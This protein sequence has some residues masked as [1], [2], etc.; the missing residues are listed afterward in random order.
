MVDE[1][2][3]R[4]REVLVSALDT[5][6][7]LGY[8]GTSMEEVAR[9]ARISR[10]GLYLYFASKPELLRAAVEHALDRDAV[11][12]EAVLADRAAPLRDRLRDAL[13]VWSGQYV[14][15]LAADLDGLIER[16]G[17]LLGDLPQRYSTRFR[18][19]LAEAVLAAAAA[20]P[21]AGGASVESLLDVL[22]TISVGLKHRARD[23][24][25]F[26]ERLDAALG[27]VLR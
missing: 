15:P 14:G 4:R 12:C 10:P 13:E 20:G 26:A 24:Q 27:I 1:K 6:A 22:L 23:R 5:F 16:D 3:D 2:P 8:R 18:A 17:A 21:V 19:A 9:R 25:D 11:A 7:R